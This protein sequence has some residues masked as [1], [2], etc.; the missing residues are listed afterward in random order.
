MKY[1]LAILFVIYSA[2]PV[3]AER[4]FRAGEIDTKQDER[5]D[6]VEHQI[7]MLFQSRGDIEA[8]LVNQS[9]AQQQLETKID[10]LLAL[11]EKPPAAQASP[12]SVV[13]PRYVAKADPVYYPSR[14]PVVASNGRY[15]T[16]ELR[17]MIR[18]KRPGGWQGAVYADVSPR[19]AAKQHLV[20]PEH[21]FSWDQVA[22][23]TQE[24]ALI[25]HD[26]APRHGNQIFPSGRRNISQPQASYI[27]PTVQRQQAVPSQV[28]QD[29][30]CPNGQCAKG[31]PVYQQPAQGWQPI[32]GRRR[33]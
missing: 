13:Q 15:S 19:S 32:F 29:L 26:L 20:G 21:G 16:E 30:G 8:E 17:A 9:A 4:V 12:A 7:K 33:R 28:I 3:H 22:G 10:K 14:A 11:A 2:I 5:L 1:L 27:P 18:A 31:Q 25:L 24:E 6:K 23:L